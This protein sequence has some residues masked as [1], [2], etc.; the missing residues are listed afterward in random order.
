MFVFRDQI[1]TGSCRI[2]SGVMSSRA[3][4]DKAHMT[5]SEVLGQ[6]SAG[7]LGVPTDVPNGYAIS[8]DEVHVWLTRLSCWGAGRAGSLAQILS[9]QER[10]KAD[11]FYFPADRERY[12][13]G[14]ALVR[15]LLGRLLGRWP[16]AL[17]FRYSEFGKPR[18][19]DDA[20]GRSLHFNVAHSEDLIV[21]GLAAQRQVGIDVERVRE[22]L[23]IDKIALRFFSLRE[24][25]EWGTVPT[26]QKQAAF[27]RCWTRKE[28]YIKARGEGLS[29]PLDQFDVSLRPGVH[30]ILLATRPDPTQ[31]IR[32]VIQDLDVGPL[33]MAAIVVEGS[34]WQLRMMEWV[35]SRTR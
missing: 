21:V 10:Q 34:N 18:L 25:A 22:D 31:A 17:T 11:R 3:L 35:P 6:Q 7:W 32:W 26:D 14:R 2:F 13:V 20:D 9:G 1:G 8:H 5:P 16:A 29:T 27:F 4:F 15:T 19:P 30:P 12:I 24:Q 33:H 23:E 28:A